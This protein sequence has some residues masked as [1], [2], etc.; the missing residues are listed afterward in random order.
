MLLPAGDFSCNRRGLDFPK[1]DEMLLSRDLWLAGDPHVVGQ[2][3]ITLHA[4]TC[5]L[6]DVTSDHSFLHD[7]GIPSRDQGAPSIPHQP[8]SGSRNRPLSSNASL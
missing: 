7:L 8:F 4:E 3:S 2:G 1:V 6:A 5:L